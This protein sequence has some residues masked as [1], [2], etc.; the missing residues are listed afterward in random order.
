M[1]MDTTDVFILLQRAYQIVYEGEWWNVTGFNEEECYLEHCKDGDETV[2][3]LEK[4]AKSNVDYYQ[5]IKIDVKEVVPPKRNSFSN[6]VA[7]QIEQT[8]RNKP[9][10]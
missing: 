5:L 4:L 1:S 10:D 9:Y 3:S 8:K 2:V 6:P 7:M